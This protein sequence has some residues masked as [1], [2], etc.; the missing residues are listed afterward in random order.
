MSSPSSAPQPRTGRIRR[1]TVSAGAALLVALGATLASAPTASAVGSSS[2]SPRYMY[3]FDGHINTNSVNLR[4][5][6][7]TSYASKGLLSKG[8]KTFLYCYKEGNATRYSWDYIKFISGPHK[9]VKGW[10]RGDFNNW[11]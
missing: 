1:V 9:G 6:P 10:V 5:G 11:W 3:Y 7:S 8:T 4:S 2:C